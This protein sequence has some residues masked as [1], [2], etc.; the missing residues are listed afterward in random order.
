MKVGVFLGSQQRGE[1]DPVRRVGE[2]VEQVRLMAAAGYDSVWLGQHYVTAPEQYFQPMPLLGRLA[3]EVGEMT[4]GTN[5]ILLPLHHPVEIAE[6]FATLDALTGGRIVLGVGLG[7]RE[8]EF[9]AFGIPIRTRVGRMTESV[10]IIKRLWTEDGVTYQGKY[11]RLTH[12][13]IRP[14]PVQ[15]PRPPLWIGATSEPAIRRAAVYGDAWMAAPSDTVPRMKEL[16]AL[17]RQARA[18]AG[19]P[20]AAD[21]AKILDMYVAPT[22][23]QAWREGAPAIAEKYRSYAAWGLGGAQSDGQ[24]LDLAIEELARDRFLIGDPDDC[25]REFRR[26]RDELGVTHL[27]IR[28]Q[29]PGMTHRQVMSCLGLVGERILPELRRA[30]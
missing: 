28:V 27:M 17:Y 30:S 4:L 10:E 23:E 25:I 8:E 2:Y 29:F 9:A 16:L 3:A 22:R 18:E 19:L 5:L 20:P 6:Q 1:D 13:S 14:R 7:Y 11:Y 24:G 12:V 21:F 15:K 26:H